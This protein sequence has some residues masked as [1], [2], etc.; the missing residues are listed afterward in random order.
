MTALLDNSILGISKEAQ[1]S[2]SQ[3]VWRRVPENSLKIARE[4]KPLSESI[5]GALEGMPLHELD[6]I[7]VSQDGTKAAIKLNTHNPHPGWNKIANLLPQQG[8]IN[9]DWVILAHGIPKQANIPSESIASP[10]AQSYLPNNSINEPTPTTSNFHTPEPY[11]KINKINPPEHL[12]TMLTLPPPKDYSHTLSALGE[13]GGYLPNG[14]Y[15]W[16][17]PGFPKHLQGMLASGLLGGAAGYGLGWVG[18]HLLPK[19]WD[20]DKFK[21]NMAI[22][23]A[24]I[25]A[26][27]GLGL[28]GLNALQGKSVFDDAPLQTGPPQEIASLSGGIDNSPQNK[29]AFELINSGNNKYPR[30]QANYAPAVH[31]MDNYELP[32]VIKFAIENGMSGLTG[33][34][35]V[36]SPTPIPIDKLNENLF[37]DPRVYQSLPMPVR[38]A[39]SG[40]M[41]SAWALKN[42]GNPSHGPRFV[43][44]A[45]VARI[46]AGM[47]SGYISGAIVGK[48]LGALLGMPE[49]TQS[50]LK[51]VGLYAGVIGNLA[52]MLFGN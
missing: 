35:I 51:E 7:A 15:S 38:A 17:I 26:A 36:F 14:K 46:T 44:P 12:T 2:L 25:G 16:E 49:Q 10:S 29:L 43:T 11:T 23:G 18:S 42:Q 27:P 50:R 9:S 40:V 22:L 8:I 24:G 6:K 39:T 47:G 1:E 5:L 30:K 3:A 41:E 34:D 32:M 19:K 52:P 4:L 21:R 20:R 28:M 45:D 33:A 13:I 31:S 37:L 48:A